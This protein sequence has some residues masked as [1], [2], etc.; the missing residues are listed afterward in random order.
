MFRSLLVP[1]D[2]SPI[3]A[4]VVGRAAL[5]P[6]T[7]G[8]RITLLHVV[9]PGLPARASSRAASDAQRAV[10]ALASEF[11]ARLPPRAHLRPAVARGLPGAEIARRAEAD[12]AEL[13][14]LGR[15]GARALRD[16]FLGSTAERVVRQSL[17]PVLAVRLPSHSGYQRPAVAIAADGAAPAVIEFL[18][19]V[20]PPPR[21]R[22]EIIHAYDLPYRGMIY[23]SLNEEETAAMLERYRQE[24]LDTLDQIVA[25]ATAQAGLAPGEAPRWRA[26]ALYGSPRSTI[27]RATE[28]IDADLLALGTHGYPGAAHAMLGTVAGDVLREVQCDVLVVPPRQRRSRRAPT[29]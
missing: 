17:L 11:A 28:R 18:L 20:V 24:A 26:H 22:V 14:V 10:E 16:A 3:C 15:G 2:L 5:L 1:V 4:R 27:A 25:S 9:P 6:L 29:N 7:P 12:G 8:A 13:I 19:R 21:P 23:P